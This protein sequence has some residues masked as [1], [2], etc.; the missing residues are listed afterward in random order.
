[1]TV[2]V[3]ELPGWLQPLARAATDVAGEQLSSFLP[4]ATGGRHSAVLMLFGDGPGPGGEELGPHVLLIQRAE[5]MRNHAGQPAFP[6]G[7]TDPEDADASATALREANEETGLDPSGV[8]V[9]HELPALFL[10]PS[11]FIVTPVLAW[12]RTPSPVAPQ[13]AAEVAR[14]VQ[15][16]IAELADPANRYRVRHPSGMIGPCFGV[17]DMAVWGFTAG[18]LDKL[19]AL[20]GWERAWEVDDVRDTPWTGPTQPPVP[21]PAA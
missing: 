20:G 3:E 8:V 1:M 2:P 6:G 11:G 16:P 12:W 10:P 19:L 9:V 15:V 13:D 5:R 7:A 18:L 17:R 21:P 14:V 4:P